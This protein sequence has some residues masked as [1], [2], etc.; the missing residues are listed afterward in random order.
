VQQ[1]KEEA[2]E[3]ARDS[4]HLAIVLAI[5]ASFT[6]VVILSKQHLTHQ[7]WACV[8]AV[9]VPMPIALYLRRRIVLL[10]VF[11]YAAA[12]VIALIAMIL[13]GL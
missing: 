2:A 11:A 4:V 3:L 10:G 12:L 5:V 8:V 13:F 1:L 9:A 7:L 6:A